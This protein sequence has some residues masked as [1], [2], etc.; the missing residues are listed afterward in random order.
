[1]GS[2]DNELNSQSVFLEN[3]EGR[4]MVIQHVL[5]NLVHVPLSVAHSQQKAV[6]DLLQHSSGRLIEATS[7]LL[8]DVSSKL[9][10]SDQFE[11][12]PLTFPLYSTLNIVTFISTIL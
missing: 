6:V 11:K 9:A 7:N 1:M 4:L 2:C 12:T 5:L 3:R 8:D 10:G